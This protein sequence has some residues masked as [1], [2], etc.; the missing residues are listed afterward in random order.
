MKKVFG[1]YTL[2]LV[3][4]WTYR[5]WFNLPGW[6][7]ELIIKPSVF[8]G[9]PV[10]YGYRIKDR[11]KLKSVLIGLGIGIIFGL[12]Q[13]LVRGAYFHL[14][15]GVTL[16]GTAIA[17]ELLFRGYIFGEMQKKLGPVATILI[18]AVMFAGIHIPIY[19]T[20]W[21]SLVLVMLSGVVYGVIRVYFGNVWPAA[22]AHFGEDLILTNFY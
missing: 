16:I 9:L 4:W 21:G 18:S 13:S 1:V 3:I 22:T 14:M 19:G 12:A 10:I 5:T 8:V 11:F 20:A 2:I 7:D 15:G 17:E 6:M